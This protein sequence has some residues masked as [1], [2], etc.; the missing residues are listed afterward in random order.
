[1][2][3]L[4]GY[5]I[6]NNISI[7][8]NIF[9]IIVNFRYIRFSYAYNFKGFDLM[10]GI[11][12]EAAKKA[13]A[14]GA[15]AVIGFTGGAS[16]SRWQRGSST[17]SAR[18]TV[19]A[20]RT[21][22]PPFY[23][24]R[25]RQ[26][27]KFNENCFQ[28]TGAG[29]EEP[30]PENWDAMEGM[31][32][33][34]GSF[35]RSLQK[36]ADDAD[37]YFCE[38][39]NPYMNSMFLK[40]D[41]VAV[42][43]TSG[44]GDRFLQAVHSTF[45]G[46][47]ELQ[48]SLNTDPDLDLRSKVIQTLVSEAA[49]EAGMATVALELGQNGIADFWAGLMAY[50]A[51]PHE[52]FRMAYD[53]GI[54]KGKSHEEA[55][56][57]A[58]S[59][60][61][62]HQIRDPEFVAYHAEKVMSDHF[63]FLHYPDQKPRASNERRA[64]DGV[65]I[66]AIG[67]MPNGYSLTEKVSISDAENIFSKNPELDDVFGYISGLSSWKP[68]FLGGNRY[69][70]VFSS[71]VIRKMESSGWALTV[72]QALNKLVDS[73]ESYI[74]A[75]RPDPQKLYREDCVQVDFNWEQGQRAPALWESFKTLRQNP[76]IVGQHV[77]DF[78]RRID[79]FY[80]YASLPVGYQG[81]WQGGSGI[82]EVMAGLS[83]RGATMN[84]QVHEA[85]HGMQ[86][87]ALFSYQVEWNLDNRQM[88]QMAFEAGAMAIEALNAFEL[89]LQGVPGPLA[90][91]QGIVAQDMK[92]AYD[93]HMEQGAGQRESLRKAG[94]AAWHAYFKLQTK[95]DFYGGMALRLYFIDIADGKIK[96]TPAGNY[97]LEKARQTGRLS[98]KFNLT[99]D[100][101]TLPSYDSRF[102]S[103]EKMREAY[104]FAEL[105][106]LEAIA[107][108]NN[109]RCKQERIRLEK[110]GNRYLH[111][112]VKEV[113]KKLAADEGLFI[114]D[115]LDDAIRRPEPPRKSAPF[116]HLPLMV[117]SFDFPAG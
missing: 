84:T 11:F 20:V 51:K 53:S 34:G 39:K 49:A 110:A 8:P 2:K 47:Q 19:P 64:K 111:V 78:S 99:A 4:E 82:A 108:K 56:V 97:M 72:V 83:D 15:L 117:K 59:A 91:F 115:V 40:E 41:G 86:D 45:H 23:P 104:D 113:A 42:I 9:D 96:D 31:R 26:Q 5:S 63:Y 116:G 79:A 35:S 38:Y 30:G 60:F 107:G 52:L 46:F 61:I 25:A 66:K 1:M 100:V 50:D 28:T 98:D 3:L 24:E 68:G 18:E 70:G 112:D 37:I 17:D 80:C 92:A 109:I 85:A 10:R 77:L 57:F 81:R 87:P 58:A 103:N 55:V 62:N 36:F 16:L 65:N 29:V 69:A 43:E 94:E 90:E 48:G 74:F 95:L 89:S 54:E 105:A 12:R 13:V 93:A 27:K 32:E 14:V 106:R 114:L 22:K 67:L 7:R 6:L 101:A 21:I 102:G 33:F 71:D 88:S 44:G 75:G 73:R 76:T